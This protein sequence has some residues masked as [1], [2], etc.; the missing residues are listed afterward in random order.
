MAA[1]E[2]VLENDPLNS[3]S[4]EDQSR[5]TDG[6]QGQGPES[7]LD[8]EDQ[9]LDSQLEFHGVSE[10][11]LF[12]LLSAA[13]ITTS[14]A[15]TTDSGTENHSQDEHLD[16]HETTECLSDLDLDDCEYEA[17]DKELDQ[18]NMCMDKLETWSIA[19]HGR[20]KQFLESTRTERNVSNET[21]E[22]GNKTSGQEGSRE[23]SGL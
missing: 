10:Q 14:F 22:N 6:N 13:N 18:L 19:L 2:M 12:S 9:D 16:I 20:V 5:T 23:A 21:L 15:N 4:N 1:K 3:M 8:L 7:I 11:Q 17:L